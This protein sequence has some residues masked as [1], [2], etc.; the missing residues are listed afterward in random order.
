MLHAIAFETL[1]RASQNL[2]S[3]YQF[4]SKSV[5]NHEPKIIFTVQN[6]NYKIQT[7]AHSKDLLSALK[8]R[9]RIDGVGFDL[10]LSIP[11]FTFTDDFDSRVDHVLIRELKS[12]AIVGGFRLLSNSGG[13]RLSNNKAFDLDLLKS[14][15]SSI[16]ELS[17]L[18]ILPEHKHPDLVNLAASYISEYCLRSGDEII[19]SAQS[20]N[21]GSSRCAAL[22]YRYF[23]SL[24]LINNFYHC[25][26]QTDYQVPNFQHWNNYFKDGLSCNELA[27]IQ[28]LLSS[29]FK[30]TLTLG[31]S[32]A[33]PP[34][35]NRMTDRIDFLTILHKEDLNRSLWKKSQHFS[36]SYFESSFS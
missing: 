6:N 18:F 4:R 11:S 8:L 7:V 10:R 19:I 32:I 23:A 27:E 28:T 34:A 22:A 26:S 30:E 29:T 16:L 14:T 35:R 36:E 13:E 33:G 15:N 24:D 12:G 1:M 3:I 17:K 5:F 25:P 2:K 9:N 20:L 21:S 31:A